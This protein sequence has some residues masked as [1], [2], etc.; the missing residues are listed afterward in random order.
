MNR[1]LI[2]SL[3]IILALGQPLL[4]RS[5]RSKHGEDCISDAACDE[6]LICRTYRC[7]T[8]FEA[9]NLKSLGLLTKDICDSKKICPVNQICVRHRCVPK[10]T[11][12]PTPMNRTKDIDDIHII[13]SGSVSLGKNAYLS[14]LKPDNTI[15]YDHIFTHISKYIKSAD[16]AVTEVDSAFYINSQSNKIVKNYKNTPKELAD[17]LVNA[18]FCVIN[19][20]SSNAYAFKRQGIIDTLNYYSTRFPKVHPLG[21]ASTPEQAN[22]DYF[23]YSQDNIKVGIVNFCG[24]FKNNIPKADQFMVNTISQQKLE[25]VLAKVKPQVDFLIVCI[26]W[27]KKTALLPTKTQILWAK[28]I[29]AYGVDVIIGNFPSEV[30][31]VSYVQASNGRKALVF[32]SLG[33]LVGESTK[34]PHLLG[35]LA[36]IVISKPPKGPAYLSSYNL[37][38]II[39]HVTKNNYTI[40]KFTEYNENLGQLVFKKFKME[41]MKNL[42]KLKMP[43][44]AHCG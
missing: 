37:I 22:E 1:I 4:K 6:G 14:G 42:C 41:K 29:A 18:G 11:P 13:F 12:L 5:R 21:I 31:P 10:D 35:A 32:F 24:L 23:I 2:F 40:Y 17:G 44:F 20:A 7:Y 8:K 36:N 27:G 3:L 38:P 33:T 26:D 16:I 43:A 15:N 9:F 28:D 19:H 39:N 30:Q 25:M 34:V